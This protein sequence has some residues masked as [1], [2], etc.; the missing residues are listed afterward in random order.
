MRTTAALPDAVSVG[1][2]RE[3]YAMGYLHGRGESGID[4]REALSFARFYVE[5]CDAA[6]ELVDVHDAYRRW[7]TTA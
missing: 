1:Y 4:R 2:A 5:R 7:S 3:Q 6:G